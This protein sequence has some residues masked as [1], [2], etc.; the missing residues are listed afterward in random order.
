MNI[1]TKEKSQDRN[2]KA[3]QNNALRTN[4][5]KVIIDMQKNSKC[6]LC[7]ER[8]ET[9]NHFVSEWNKLAQKK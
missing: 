8:D 2:W 7:G 4:Y 1:A 5:I 3:A 9:I 6:R